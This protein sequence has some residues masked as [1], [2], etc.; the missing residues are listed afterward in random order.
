MTF[1]DPSAF[2]LTKP[3]EEHWRKIYDEYLGVRSDLIDWYE[4][5]LYGE[6]WK[7]YKLFDFPHGGA[8]EENIRKCPFTASLIQAHV[9]RRGAAGFSV[10]RP[11]T[12]INPHTGYQG[13]FLRCHLGLRVP[14]GDCA[15]KVG[16]E[17]RRWQ[18]GKVLVFDDRGIHESWNLTHEERV[19]LLIDFI[20]QT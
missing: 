5:E 6:G 20:P 8:V 10:L 1:H 18:D 12:R 16:D 13:E 2:G 14:D 4:R 7:V 15:L 19:I 3:L 11:M 17:T 9:S